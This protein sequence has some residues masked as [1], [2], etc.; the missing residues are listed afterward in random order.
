MS[1][2]LGWKWTNSK[3][4]TVPR[5]SAKN[6]KSSQNLKESVSCV[7]LKTYGK[8]ATNFWTR[9]MPNCKK[10]PIWISWCKQCNNL[11]WTLCLS[12]RIHTCATYLRFICIST[13]LLFIHVMNFTCATLKGTWFT[14]LDQKRIRWLFLHLICCMRPIPKSPEIN[15]F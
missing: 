12:H 9:N 10:K 8:I 3:K 7:H 1:L 5:N 15:N 6:L 14:W 2:K 13:L 4:Q 11:C